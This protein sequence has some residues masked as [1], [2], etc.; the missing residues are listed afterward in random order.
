MFASH[1]KGNQVKTL[2]GPAAVMVRSF[3]YATD[4]FAREGLK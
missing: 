2:N 3:K 1:L 4:D